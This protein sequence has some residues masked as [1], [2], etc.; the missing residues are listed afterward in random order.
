[1]DR[2]ARNGAGKRDVNP[3]KTI[4]KAFVARLSALFEQFVN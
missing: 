4:A 3:L 2:V 1:M